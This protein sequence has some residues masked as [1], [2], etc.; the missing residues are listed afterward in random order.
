MKVYIVIDSE[1]YTEI[2]IDGVFLHLKDALKHA[3]ECDLNP[4]AVREFELIE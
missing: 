3:E 2:Q 1:D 4:I